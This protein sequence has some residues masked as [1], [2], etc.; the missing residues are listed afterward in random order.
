[1]WIIATLATTQN[2]P[3]KKKEK[4]ETTYSCGTQFRVTFSFREETEKTCKGRKSGQ[5]L[6]ER[7]SDPAGSKSAQSQS[8]S[9][10]WEKRVRPSLTCRILT[11]SCD[12]QQWLMILFRCIPDISIPIACNVSSSFTIDH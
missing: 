3:Q 5:G 9:A 2:L 10:S 1:M 8:R 4:K 12:L 6:G 7:E 11:K